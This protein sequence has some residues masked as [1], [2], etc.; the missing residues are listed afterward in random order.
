VREGIEALRTGIRLDPYDA[1]VPLRWTQIVC[2]LYFCSDYEAALSEAR[3]LR[4]EYPEIP[5]AYRWIAAALG[6]LGRTAEAREALAAAIAVSPTSFDLYVRNRVPW[7]RPEDYAHMLDG[8]RNAG[9]H[10]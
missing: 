7:M 6:Q 1:T 10:G 9:W 5:N 8:L 4:R 3:Q 2:G